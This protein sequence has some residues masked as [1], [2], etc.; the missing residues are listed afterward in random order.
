MLH[1]SYSR[2]VVMRVDYQI[3]LNSPPPLTLLAGSAT[4]S[5]LLWHYRPL[6]IGLPVLASRRLS[7]VSSS[8]RCLFLDLTCF[9]LE[10]VLLH[11]YVFQTSNA[12][13]V[14]N[15]LFSEICLCWLISRSSLQSGLTPLVLCIVIERCYAFLIKIT[16]NRDGP[17]IWL[18]A[19]LK[20][21]RLADR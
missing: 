5:R 18:G 12:F 7:S 1:L 19:P 16:Y 14:Q 17:L 6:S 20:R 4:G 9:T 10:T 8:I 13:I 2:E 21:P 11:T 3:I 15:I